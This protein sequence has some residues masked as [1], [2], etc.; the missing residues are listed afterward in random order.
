M[1]EVAFDQIVAAMPA[2]RHNPFVRRK[3]VTTSPIYSMSDMF[4]PV[5]PLPAGFYATDDKPNQ[6]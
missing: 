5:V 1:M 6:A 2:D 4:P 3:S